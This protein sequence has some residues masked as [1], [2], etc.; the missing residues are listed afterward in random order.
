MGDGTGGAHTL[1]VRVLGSLEVHR[2]D[3]AVPLGGR[4]QQAVL[5]CLI[6]A[7]SAAVPTEQI[8]DAIWGATPP[9]GY[10]STLQTYVFHL[11]E[12]V[13]PERPKGSPGRLLVTVAGG[14]A[15]RIPDEAIDARRFERLVA[16]GRGMLRTDPG[17]ASRLLTEALG[18][19]RG[20]VMADLSDVE[21]VAREASRLDELRQTALEAWCEAELALGHHAALAPELGRLVAAYPLREGLHA[22]R[23]LALYRDERQA[24]ALDAYRRLRA[25]LDEELGVEPS[26][27][28]RSLHERI[29]RQD[30]ALEWRPPPGEAS[31]TVERP[32]VDVPLAGPTGVP[33][34]LPPHRRRRPWGA[35]VAVAAIAAGLLSWTVVRASRADDV[36]PVPPNSLAMVTERGLEGDAVPLG[37]ADVALASTTGTVWAVDSAGNAL[38]RVDPE[39]HRVLQTIPGVGGSPQ[40]VAVAGN[41]V[42][43]TGFDESVLVRVN[44]ASNRIV[45][46]IPV[47]VQPAAV[48][49]TADEVWV[50][51]SGDNTV[52]RVDPHTGKADQ[53]VPVGEGPAGLALDGSLLWVANSRSG[54]VSVLER[55]SG[56]RHESDIA[57]QAGPRGLTVTDDDVWVTNELGQS[58]TRISR[59]DR[60]LVT[61]PVEDGPSSLVVT[62][63][64]AWVNNAYSG[65]VSRISVATNEVKRIALG[66]APRALTL[67]GGEVWAATGAFG[68]AEHLGGTLVLTSPNP[69][70]DTHDPASIGLPSDFAVLSHV[71]DGLVAFRVAGGL[72]GQALVPDLATSIPR[73]TDGGRTYVFTIRPG[74]RYST[75]A[76]VKASDFITG[77]RRAL[78]GNGNPDQ[79]A[80]V[81]GAG[82][83]LKARTDP[84]RCDL[85]Q[86]M[87][88]DD[89][90]RRLTIRL[91]EPDAD[92]LAKLTQFVVPA[93]S[94][95]SLTP[96]PLPGTLPGTGPYKMATVATDGSFTLVRNPYFHLWSFAAQ[97]AAYPDE[98]QYQVATSD[99]DAIAQVLAGRA[100]VT[101]IAT[102]LLP[103]LGSHAELIRSY[104]N[105]NTDWAY[106][107]SR[108]PPFDNQ[109]ARQALNYAVDRRT[110]VTLYGGGPGAADLACQLLPAGTPGYQRYC[111]YQTGPAEGPY[112]GPDL[113]RARQLVR[114][115][116]TTD[117]P[118]TV[119][120]YHG[121]PLWEAFPAYLADVLR[122]IGYTKVTIEDMPKDLKVG[123]NTGRFQI[124]T[125]LGWLA[126]FPSS[127]PSFYSQFSCQ[128]ANVS[129]YCNPTIETVA[130]QARAA[131]NTDPSRANTLWSHV[132]RMLTDDAAFVTLG[133]HHDSVLTSE[134]V[135]NVELRPGLGPILS[136]LWVK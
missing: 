29:L 1:D 96:I 108:M 2:G 120:A 16:E 36:T 128:E 132:D 39:S 88:A 45:A 84:T 122:S 133:S 81:V 115:S 5:A 111:P 27:A 114:E 60:K 121:Y 47:G 9:P 117:V 14:Y 58:V 80:A 68:N 17:R 38:V 91:T 63:G 99:E 127:A 83:C 70:T 129:G 102:K 46:R 6:V 57:V 42:W 20:D 118:I 78:V 35:V 33:P 126:D 13:E 7:R 3:G 62:D 8:A 73:P 130:A 119:H 65:S 103:G 95:S 40:A 101:P 136:Q 94:G 67:V 125:W 134:R 30:P 28:L 12:M 50:A 116:G 76:E 72:A 15:L 18:L 104:P 66:S 11:R 124:F 90:N 79:Y 44:A 53:A 97:P 25:T 23:M 135:R 49:A 92:F 37:T 109:K 113:E 69:S 82:Q 64:F 75:G 87:S 56:E 123:Q 89:A 52:Q 106:L 32:V 51:N 55:A 77:M 105:Y 112:L 100:D 61:I 110:F 22:Q 131:A 107:N 48:V 43:V 10:L 59:T 98:I 34:Q 24:Q 85:S 19:W 41:D 74:I 31:E 21:P 71:Y 93:P 4:R 54:S 26:L 86:G